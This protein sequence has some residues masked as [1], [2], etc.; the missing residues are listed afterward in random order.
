MASSFAVVLLQDFEYPDI[1]ALV[2][3][4]LRVAPWIPRTSPLVLLTMNHMFFFFFWQRR[5]QLVA[6]FEFWR[7]SPIQ[8]GSLPT[9]RLPL[10]G[11]WLA[12]L[13][14]GLTDLE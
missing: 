11:Y 6:E 10:L 1:A 12:L 5:L 4:C 13:A 7:L 9:T 3:S 14:N 8:V 2:F